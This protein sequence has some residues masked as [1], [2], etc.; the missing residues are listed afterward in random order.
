MHNELDPFRELEFPADLP[1]KKKRFARIRRITKGTYKG[2]TYISPIAGTLALVL[3]GIGIYFGYPVYENYKNTDPALNGYVAPRSPGDIVA[4]AQAGTVTIE[5]MLKNE[6]YYLGSGWA[7][8]LKPSSKKYK[9]SIITNYHVLDDCFDGKGTLSVVDEDLKKWPMVID[10]LDKKNDLAKISSTIK[11]VPLQLAPYG[12]N[13]GF[14][15]MTYG[16][17]DGWV[18]SV[19][20]GSVLNSTDTEI[21]I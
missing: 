11:L 10:I 17:S 1:V 15:V 2:L 3:V 16:T 13:P 14:W 7:I 19:S 21:F 4:I 5:C 12:P 20:F 6:D 18:G 8:D 9:T